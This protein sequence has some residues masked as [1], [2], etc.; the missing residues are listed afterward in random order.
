METPV[1]QEKRKQIISE[2]RGL[3][4]STELVLF[5]GDYQ[6]LPVVL[7]PLDLPVYR[8]GNGRLA[9][10]KAEYLRT[11]RKNNDYFEQGEE[12]PEVQDALYG[13]L[14]ELAKDPDASIYQELY[15]T[16]IQTERIL[17]THEGIVVDG[18]RRLASMRTLYKEDPAKFSSF[19]NVETILLPEDAS[20][21]DLELVEANRQLAPNTKLAY[22]WIDRRLKLRYHRFNLGIPASIICETY[23]LRSEAQLHTELEEL[24]LAEQYLDDYLGLASDY[25]LI[26][27]AEKYFVSLRNQLSA[28]KNDLEKQVWRLIGFAMIKEANNPEFTVGN[29]YPLVPLK[30]HFTPKP[31]LELYGER[32]ELWSSSDELGSG[33]VMNNEMYK[34]LL[35]NLNKSK[36]ST[37]IAETIVQLFN[38]TIVEHEERPHPIS[39]VG[40]LRNM[41][42]MLSKIDLSNFTTSQ[43]N[44][45][46]GHLTEVDYHIR[47]LLKREN[48]DNSSSIMIISIPGMLR[49]IYMFIRKGFIWV[50]K[51]LPGN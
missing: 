19:S 5:R 6:A 7:L 36:K 3:T 16:G 31:V 45:M 13:M 21:V 28:L 44:E 23:R 17:V 12:L 49:R 48:R 39:V 25:L 29:Y 43:R 15:N 22:S 46:Y 38:Q 50:R 32:M 1:T 30:Y 51:R 35:T 40:H 42:I 2:R 10:L 9:V 33:T 26:Y 14:I 41:S 18:N 34:K 20:A 27:D 11:H 8:A 4:E 24:E 37:E 47:T